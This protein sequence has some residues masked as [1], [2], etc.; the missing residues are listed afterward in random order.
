[1]VSA[2]DWAKRVLVTLLKTLAATYGC[3]LGLTRESGDKD[4][5]KAFKKVLGKVVGEDA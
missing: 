4:V 5:Q 2:S 1:M 3:V